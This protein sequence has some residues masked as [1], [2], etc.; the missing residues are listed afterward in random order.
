MKLKR[1]FTAPVD[2]ATVRSRTAVYFALAGYQQVSGNLQFKRGSVTGSTMSFNPCNWQCEAEVRIKPGPRPE[3][4]IL[5]DIHC[6]PFEKS[7]SRTLWNEE[8]DR[9]QTYLSSGDIIPFDYKT[10]TTRVRNYVLRIIGLPAGLFL[11]ILFG[12]FAGTLIINAG[13]PSKMA[14]LAGLTVF[15]IL[16]GLIVFAW[17]RVKK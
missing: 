7:I 6:D 1:T 11:A 9:F 12:M 2:E 16:G 13:V 4:L 14:L 17:S 3:C 8:L 10:N 5:Y 15:V